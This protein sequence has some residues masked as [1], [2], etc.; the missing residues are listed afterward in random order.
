MTPLDFERAAQLA[1]A[2]LRHARTLGLRPL[3][4]AVLDAAGHPL[5]VLRDEQASFLRPQIASGKA[6]GCLGMGF[7]GREL[8]RRAQAMPAFFDAINSLTGGEVIPVP[9]GILLRDDAGNLLG[10]IGVSGDTSDNDERCALLAIEELGLHG[11]T[12]DAQ[13]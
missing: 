10:A 3:A 8:A 9:G 11:D 5:A 4:A 12:G 7:G 6:R 1:A 13:A 2:T